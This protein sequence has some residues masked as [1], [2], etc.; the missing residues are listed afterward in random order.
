MVDLKT[1]SYIGLIGSKRQETRV[2]R[3]RPQPVKLFLPIKILFTNIALVL[4]S[5]S[6]SADTKTTAYYCVYDL[7]W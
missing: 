1:T 4:K 7:K 5:R 3:C 6:A 2:Y